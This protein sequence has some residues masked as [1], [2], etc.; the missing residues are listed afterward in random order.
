MRNQPK[1]KLKYRQV[2]TEETMNAFKND[3]LAE[4]MGNGI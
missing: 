4:K 1:E 2:R 3:L